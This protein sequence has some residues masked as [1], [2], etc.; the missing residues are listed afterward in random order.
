MRICILYVLH[1]TSQILNHEILLNFVQEFSM[2]CFQ[3]EIAW[4]QTK[5]SHFLSIF[6][7][8]ET[9]MSAAITCYRCTV[10][11]TTQTCRQFSE[12]DEFTVDCPF[13]TMCLKKVYRLRLNDGTEQETVSR[14]CA[15]QK[16]T[17][18]V[19]ILGALR[20]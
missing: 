1:R 13:S 7:L 19:N 10:S 20:N 2:K 16:R 4:H 3:T 8:Y 12:S 11:P 17:E 14:D 6:F 18:E 15:K 9:D 5:N